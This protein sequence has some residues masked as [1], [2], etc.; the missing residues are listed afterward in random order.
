MHRVI[1]KAYITVHD[2]SLAPKAGGGAFVVTDV[3]SVSGTLSSTGP[4]GA[5]SLLLFCSQ[6][7]PTKWARF[8]P[9]LCGFSKF[10]LPANAAAVPFAL[11]ARVRD[12]EAYEPTT[13]AFEVY[14]GSYT[15]S[16]A[17]DAGSNPLASW[18]VEVTGSYEWTWDFAGA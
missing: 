10:A 2:A 11:S 4:A 18:T 1:Q 12:L 17:T 3:L 7:A 16:L 6:N 5:L 15:V 14:T 13:A 9:Q 8:G